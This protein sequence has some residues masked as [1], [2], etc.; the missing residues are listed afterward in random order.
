IL[1]LSEEWQDLSEGLLRRFLGEVMP[2]IER[3]SAHV[4]RNLFPVI[5]RIEEPADDTLRSPQRQERARDLRLAIS[6]VMDEIDRGRGA[7]VLAGG[8]NRRLIAEAALVFG[9]GA[10]IEMR[11]TRRPA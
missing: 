9:E 10:R 2:A 6:A 3:L 1:P 5:D 7:I 8:V 4:G 11:E